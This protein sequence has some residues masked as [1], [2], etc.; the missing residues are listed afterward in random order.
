[1][2][3]HSPE[4]QARARAE[5]RAAV[6]GRAATA[7][8]LARAPYIEQVLQET[9]RLYPPV[10]M[11]ARNVLEPDRLYDREIRPNDTVFLNI[12][13]LH[14]HRLYWEAPERFEPDT[15]APERVAARDRYL[16]LPFGAGP[17]ICVGANF[18][19]M[20]AQIILTTLLAR[21]AFEPA[22]PVPTP[23]MHMTIR[24]EPGVALRA[25]PLA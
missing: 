8:D 3:A 15:F 13:A 2:L 21:F 4:A 25:R 17:R 23:I 14:R 22:G 5:A 20:Q 10:G 11:L 7:E 9:M 12:Y 6:G 1:M 18:A 19:M 24:P 16:H